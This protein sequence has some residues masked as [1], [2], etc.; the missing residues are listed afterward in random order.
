MALRDE[1]ATVRPTRDDDIA[2]VTAIYCQY[3]LESAATFEIEP[4]GVAEM[5]RRWAELTA[6]GYPHLVAVSGGEV[7]GY[8][9]AGPYRAR[10]AYRYTVEDS[11]YVRAG[12]EGRG[13]G[14]RLLGSLIEACETAGFRQM[15]A[16]IGD[17]APASIAL[18]ARLGFKPAGVLKGV[19]HKFGRWCDT[20]LMQR[21]LK[22]SGYNC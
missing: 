14:T 19:G 2:G 13:L 3:V 8:A 20:T 16:I 22:E 7:A 12:L 4:P 9:C 10:P 5:A 21:G 6:A 1:T 17:N 11:V 18:H 15:I